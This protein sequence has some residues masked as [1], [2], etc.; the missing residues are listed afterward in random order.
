MT[1]WS[2]LVMTHMYPWPIGVLVG[3]SATSLLFGLFG[4]RALWRT[5]GC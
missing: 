1:G 4:T 3:A 5:G 2:E